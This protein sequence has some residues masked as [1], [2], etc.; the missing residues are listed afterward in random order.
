MTPSS[1]IPLLRMQGN[2]RE[3]CNY[4]TISLT[5]HASTFILNILLNLLSAS[6]TYHR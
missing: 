4:H 3:R 5:C 6:K 1:L 2:L